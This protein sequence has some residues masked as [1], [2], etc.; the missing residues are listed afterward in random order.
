M[1]LTARTRGF[2]NTDEGIDSVAALGGFLG[3][4]IWDQVLSNARKPPQ[5]VNP[6]AGNPG[7]VAA[8]A[9][10]ALINQAP[11]TI[12][13]KSLQRLMVS[14][15]AVSFYEQTDRPLSHQNMHWDRIKNFKVQYDTIKEKKTHGETLSVPVIGKD[16]G[17]VRWLEAYTSYA[18]QYVGV[19]DAFISYVIRDEAAVNPVAPPLAP[20]EPHSIEHGSVMQDM[21]HRFSHTH[22]LFADDNRKV[23]DDLELATRGTKYAASIAPFKRTKNGRESF[24]T[25]KAQHAGPAMWDAQQRT[26]FDFLL[27][28]KFTDGG[29]VTLER[30]IAQ[31]RNAFTS[32]QRCSENVSVQVPEERMRVGYLIENIICADPDV[33][34][35]LAAIKLDDSP[36]GLR[37]NFERAAALLLPV[38]PVERKKKGKRTIG[39]ISAATAK[40]SASG[41]G[42]DGFGPSGVQLRY[43]T[44]K[45]YSQLSKAERLDLAEWR[46]NKK[47]GNFSKRGKSKKFGQKQLRAHVASLLKEQ[48]KNDAAKNEKLDEAKACLASMISAGFTSPTLAEIAASRANPEAEKSTNGKAKRVKFDNV[49]DSHTTLS[50]AAAAEIC[51]TKFMAALSLNEKKG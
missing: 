28:R 45:E 33:K 49:A 42:K 35:A 8:V 37:N 1:G 22:A 43:H 19:R 31:H 39:N 18:S 50:A 14:A 34:A 5:V 25:L 47:E 30:F 2:L 38:D 7:H 36:T 6:A 23:F 16:L 12:S 11:F 20:N 13:A 48:Q 41:G 26:D 3:K 24:L 21:V 46:R 10:G 40:P 51:A 4:E 44:S 27:N 17:I 15:V 9:V 32:L 29:T